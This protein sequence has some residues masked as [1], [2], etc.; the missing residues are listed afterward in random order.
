MLVIDKER[1]VFNVARR[2]FVDPAIL[3]AE[4]EKIFGRCW[5]YLGHTSE[6]AKPG[7]FV[8]RQ[9][10]GRHII[11]ARN[12]K[13]E[14]RA[15]LNTCAHR[16]AKVCRERAGNAKSFQC[17]YHGWIFGLDGNLRNLPD[18]EAYPADFK[19]R[20]T[21]GLQPVPRFDTYRGFAFVCFDAD[22][23]S[24]SDY[25][26]GAKEYIDIVADQSDLGMAIVGGT[27]E[28]SIRANWK[29]LAE[30]SFDGYHAATNHATYLDY[31]KN[32]NGGLANVA[33]KGVSHDLGN[34]HAVVEYSAPWGR[35]VAQWIPMWGDQ[36][37]V[38]ID[39]IYERLVE[40]HGKERADRIA[41]R[42][43]NLVIFP[44]LVI[45][46]IMAITVR[47]FYPTAPDFML[48]NAWA[49]APAEESK[50][51]REYRLFNFLEFLG[52]GGFATP[53]DV[54]A[55]EQ[56]QRGYANM[57]EVGWNDMSKGMGRETPSY[58]DEAQM[59]AFWAQWNQRIFEAAA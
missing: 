46:D 16:G 1:H 34:G 57:A 43:R 29:L 22:A 53:D 14:L 52:P 26:A 13:G 25:L 35:P 45:N 30:N 9:V 6:L 37:K 55:L 2:T 44:N 39:A 49:L 58:D 19:A 3:E 47:T 56:C 32:T 31:L 36:G 33:L 12:P 51:A 40:R 42:N 17:F 28:Y 4:R 8:T 48:I 41:T 54:E 21:S 10:G 27:Q 7:D 20:S 50:W 18:E 38:E 59:R 11:F 23:V 24:L 5:L 15:L